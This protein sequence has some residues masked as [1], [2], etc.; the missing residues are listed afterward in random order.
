MSTRSLFT[1]LRGHNK[2]QTN[3]FVLGMSHSTS[4]STTLLPEAPD[5]GYGWIIVFT[6]FMIHFICDGISFSFGILFPQIQ[7]NFN[8][9]TTMSGIIGSIFLSMPLLLGPVAGVLTD[10]Y[11]CRMTI[12]GGIIAASGAFVSYFA[13]GV[14]QFLFTF[15]VIVGVGLC[16]CFN[17]AIV[18]VTYYF[19]KKRAL[20]TGIAVCGSGAG[21][22]IFAPFLEMVC[23]CYS[24]NPNALLNK[25]LPKLPSSYGAAQGRVPASNVVMFGWQCHGF[26]KL[27]RRAPSAPVIFF[28]RKRKSHVISFAKWLS[29]VVS[30]LSVP[31]FSVYLVSTFIL[32]LF[33]DIP[34][35]NFPEHATQHLNVTE[36]QSS[37]LVATIGIFNTVSMLVCGLL[38]DWR[39]CVL[40]APFVKSYYVLMALC[41]GF[42]FF[43]SA[44][45]VL[46]SVI[47]VH[48]LCLYDFQTGY[49]LLCLVEGLGNLF[50]PGLVGE[51]SLILQPFVGF[52][53]VY[54]LNKT[55]S[56]FT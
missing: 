49:G 21:T 25:E 3:F 9:T 32:Y 8:T 38:A 36:T 34:Y 40:I 54:F 51:Y 23:S 44:N 1:F 12:V 47:T 7:E 2:V 46:A 48:L 43:I 15:G 41:A 50:G 52:L 42:G 17:T 4:T 18:A 56:S 30:L 10:I 33:F 26:D 39:M 45:Y 14:W 11:D 55:A 6:S 24:Q 19:Q 27:S 5:G 29:V 20:A 13:F 35:V 37:Y 31:S 28:R 22:A 16:L 53:F